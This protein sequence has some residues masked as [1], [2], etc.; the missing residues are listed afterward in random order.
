[1]I[2]DRLLTLAN[3]QALSATGNTVDVIDLGTDRDVGPGQ[4]LW[5][6]LSIDVAPDATNSDETYTFTLTTDDNSG[7]SSATTI[8]TQAVPRG[9]PAGTRYVHAMPFA[10]ERWLRGTFTLGGTTPSVTFTAFITSEEPAYL[11]A[12]P[13]AI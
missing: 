3:A 10:N 8:I 13:N 4:R 9:T 11:A 12:Y 1:M 2:I 6:V 7:F 5:F